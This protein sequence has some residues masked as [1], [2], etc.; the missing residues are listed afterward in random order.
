MMTTP[1]FLIHL[2]ELGATDLHP[3]R[4]QATAALIRALAVR[5][6]QRLLEV[7]C[8]A[9]G[10]MVQVGLRQPVQIDGVD[11]LPPM[12]RVA[13]QRLRLA[14]LQERTSLSRAT[15]AALPFAAQTYDRVYTESVL[16]FQNT[17]DAQ[18]MLAHIFRVLKRGGLYVANEAI[19]KRGVAPERV[20]AIYAACMADFGICQASEQPWSVDD[21]LN[22]AQSVGFAVLDAGLLEDRLSPAADPAPRVHWRQ[23]LADGLTWFYR[24]RGHLSPRLRR[25]QTAYRR[26]LEAHREDGR[27]MESRL[28]VL[29]KP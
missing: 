4:R 7:G 17:A 9:G 5:Q 29:A 22:L 6:G 21:W 10:T 2:A 13:Q 24:A 25:Q 20:A 19:W 11:A 27:Y 23:R 1:H 18:A 3:L 12:L 8:G 28:F 14:G 15:A 26:R 16:G